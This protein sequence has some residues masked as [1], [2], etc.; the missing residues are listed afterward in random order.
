MRIFFHAYIVALSRSYC[1]YILY[2]KALTVF[3]YSRDSQKSATREILANPSLF[4]SKPSTSNKLVA[5]TNPGQ[6]QHD[7][8]KD[9]DGYGHHISES[10]LNRVARSAV[11]FDISDAKPRIVH[12]HRTSTSPG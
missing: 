5:L 4:S 6:Y 11:G 2:C 3:Y 10:G 1:I 7:R 8:H 12:S 9:K